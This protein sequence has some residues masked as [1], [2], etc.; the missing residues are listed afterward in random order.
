M[1]CTA[2]PPSEP[3]PVIHLEIPDTLTTCEKR[4]AHP[5]PGI[6]APEPVIV[7]EPDALDRALALFRRKDDPVPQTAPTARV[8]DE[9]ARLRWEALLM[10]AHAD[11][12]SKLARVKELMKGYENALQTPEQATGPPQAQD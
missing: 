2:T 10:H 1:G 12:Q 8:C 4:P 3:P 9:K 11:C 5:C 7:E 6:P